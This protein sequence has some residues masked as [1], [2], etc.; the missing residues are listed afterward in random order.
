[1]TKNAVIILT[2]LGMVIVSTGCPSRQQSLCTKID[3]TPKKQ[4][5]LADVEQLAEAAYKRR[6]DVKQLRTAIK[7]W[8]DAVAIAPEKT[9]NYVKL[10]RALYLLGDGYLRLAEED[11][12][13]IA[14]LEEATN[15]AESAISIRN[16]KFRN[17]VC[18]GSDV[19]E[20]VDQLTVEDVPA[21]YWYSTALGKWGLANNILVALKNKDKIFA[22]MQR[23]R[24][25]NADY[26]Y[27]A[28]DRYLGAFYT[29]IPF[30]S[31]DIEKSQK[32]FETSLK[33]SPNYLATSVLMAKM[34]APKLDDEDEGRKMY[35][36]R[37]EF[38]LNAPDDIIPELA[39][40]HRLE[41]QKAKLLLEEIDDR[42]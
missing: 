23:V 26:W 20:V 18:E 41:K 37:L 5:N 17:A 14:A 30:P 10:S 6:G 11:D 21:V 33:R 16:K 3:T 31:G 25:L 22:M 4:G 36:E 8:R 35:K 19:E 40:E 27:G 34:L 7:H 38:V 24:E 29:K 13:M 39:P 32:H 2:L 15:L 9:E 42:F 12:A 1:M 28:V